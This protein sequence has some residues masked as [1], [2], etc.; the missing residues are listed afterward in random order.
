L[1]RF[2]WKSRTSGEE[3]FSDFDYWFE[4]GADIDCRGP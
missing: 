2:V 1:K 4:I 3:I